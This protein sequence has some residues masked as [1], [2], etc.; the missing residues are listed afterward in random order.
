MSKNLVLGV[1]VGG[2]GIKGGLVDVKKGEMVSERFRL[3]TPQ[4]AVPKSMAETFAAVVKHF[5]YDGR[6]GCGFPAIIKNGVAKSAANIDKSW[7]NTD[8]AKLFSKASK[9]KVTVVNDAD[10]A[11]LASSYF[12]LGKGEKGVVLFLT[13][14]SGIGSALFLNGKLVP[15][16]ELG[17]LFL[18]GQEDIA[19][20]FA[21]D[22][23]RKRDNLSWLDWGARFNVYLHHVD[24]LFSPDLIILGGG[25]SKHFEKYSPSL[26]ISTD[27]KP[28]TMQ[29][30][31]GI[32]GAAVCALDDEDEKSKGNNKKKK[33]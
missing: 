17:H 10:A 21:A 19:E 33:K 27:V 25:A 22:S 24:R 11:G 26:D 14:G 29:N 30:M 28:S 9:C 13:I 12:G 15:N 31:A 32:I 7:I 6:V 5:D 4:P 1:D 2:S 8:A 16:T 20:R 18:K 23:A 3:A